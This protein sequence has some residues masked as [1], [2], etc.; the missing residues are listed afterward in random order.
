[1][2]AR[3]VNVPTDAAG[4]RRT[5]PPLRKNPRPPPPGRHW[6]QIRAPRSPRSVP[7]RGLRGMDCREHLPQHLGGGR[8]GRPLRRNP[9]RKQLRSRTPD[10][11]NFGSNVAEASE[12]RPPLPPP[13][14]GRKRR[15]LRFRSP[16]DAQQI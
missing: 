15:P 11:R 3:D 2:N 1:M 16:P 6:P 10:R 5:N 7:P 12:D 14:L 13:P 8:D 4:S 9:S